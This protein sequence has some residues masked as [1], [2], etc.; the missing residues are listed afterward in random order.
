MPGNSKLLVGSG[1]GIAQLHTTVHRVQRGAQLQ[2]ADAPPETRRQA[3][4]DHS[5]G[6]VLAHL[7]EGA[8]HRQVNAQEFVDRAGVGCIAKNSAKLAAASALY[9]RREADAQILRERRHNPHIW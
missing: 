2:G 4:I 7:F 5:G 1:K 6:Q 9:I 8:E 3:R